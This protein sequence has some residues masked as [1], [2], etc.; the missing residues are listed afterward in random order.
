MGETLES[1]GRLRGIIPPL[2][3]P[4][5]GRDALDVDGLGWLI[6]HVIA[7]GVHGIFVLGSTGEAP[8]LGDRLRGEVAARAC[9]LVGGRVPVLVG[10]A[11]TAAARSLELA[12]RAADAG[13][14]AVVLTTPYYYPMSADDLAGYLERIV[15]ELPLPV[16]L[17][18]IPQLTKICIDPQT[19]VRATQWE[20]VIGLKDSSGDR[21][22]LEEAIRIARSRP[23]WSLFVGAEALLPDAVAL[24][25]RG[26]ICGGANLA[27]RLFVDLYQ[28]ADARDE[29]RVASLRRRVG[30][31]GNAYRI[32]PHLSD[33]IR[34]QKLCLSL[35]GICPAQMAEPFAGPQPPINLVAMR[36]A[37]RSC[38]L[39]D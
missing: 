21:A 28:A 18:N 16:M 10:I 15:A 22:Y 31:L 12:R 5:A 13:A 9:E 24:G 36:D 35:M 4:L 17:Y 20:R 30:D 27:P 6:E 38:G 11:D 3:T 33:S 29:A 19:L 1:F 32:G 26:G 37:L 23:D 8:S 39:I 25:G 34:G 14:A 7:G 2:V